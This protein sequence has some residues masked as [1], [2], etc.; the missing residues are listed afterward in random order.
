VD[1]DSGLVHRSVVT[2]ANVHDVTQTGN[3][4]H[5]SEEEVYGDSGYL[6]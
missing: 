6:Y 3:L 5:G 2:L 4:L 1:K